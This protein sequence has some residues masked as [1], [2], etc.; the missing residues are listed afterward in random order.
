MHLLGTW[1]R[2]FVGSHIANVAKLPRLEKIEDDAAWHPR[3]VMEAWAD[4]LWTRDDAAALELLGVLGLFDRPADREALGA[5]LQGERVH[6]LNGRLW[7]KGSA[8][9]DPA[10]ATL[11][12]AGLVVR[13]RLR[14]QR[15]IGKTE[16]EIESHP[17]V[18]EH[19][20]ERL[21][22]LAPAAW[23]AGHERLYRHFAEVAE[24]WPATLA[25]MEPLFRAVLHGCAAGRHEEVLGKVFVQ[26]IRRG[27]EHYTLHKLGA[28]AAE[29][30]AL[31]GFFAAPWQRPQPALTAPGQAWVLSAAGAN[32]YALGRLAEAVTP[33]EAG[34]ARYVEQAAWNLAAAAAGNLADLLLTLGCLGDAP[35]AAPGAVERAREAV[36]HA[37][38]SGDGFERFS[39]RTTLA[40]ALH[41]QG[42]AAEARAI[43]V[44]A[45][46]LQSEHQPRLPQLYSL[47]GFRYGDLL[48]TLGDPAEARRRAKQTMEWMVAESHA[49][50]LTIALDHLLLG[51]AALATVP[52]SDH[53]DFALAHHHLDVAVTGL[54]KSGH[55]DFI[56]L[57][58]LARA[59]LHRHAAD[60][61]AA[62]AD[63]AAAHRIATRGGMR[64]HL[65]D[66]QLESARL[67]LAT[68]DRDAA[69][70]AYTTARAEVDAM[71]YHRRDPELA[72]LAA[73][74]DET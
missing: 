28:F 72:A 42:R 4:R 22:R 33:M 11:R 48:L 20:G 8:V 52:D 35:A 63:L 51:R 66:H 3:R 18:R 68:G 39:E 21:R 7:R 61:P 23:K 32:L 62:R 53:P 15:S 26:R 24:F 60:W 55:Q 46:R 64:L 50:L 47:Q 69:R 70:T 9:I 54:R 73:A 37:D 74:L 36:A 1:L 67:F 71:G 45:E 56:P 6:G 19:F 5:V 2:G 38:R 34:L 12:A 43:F 49:P 13:A 41:H 16:G 14:G 10:L 57:G 29:L 59:A 17:L 65:A 44:E 58:H 25:D 31:A 40:D 30:A 27:S